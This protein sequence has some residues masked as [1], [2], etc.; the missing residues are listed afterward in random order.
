VIDSWYPQDAM[1]G[2]ATQFNSSNLITRGF[3]AIIKCTD[4]EA[5]FG[6]L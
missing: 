6:T 4:F 5:M 1:E 2:K 3:V